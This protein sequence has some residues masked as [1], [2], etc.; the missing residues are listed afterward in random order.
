MVICLNMEIIF[1]LEN[2]DIDVEFKP[3]WVSTENHGDHTKVQWKLQDTPD[4]KHLDD[5]QLEFSSESPIFK[6]N[7]SV[8]NMRLLCGYN[9]GDTDT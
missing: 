2:S 4:T 8:G 3:D 1:E 7:V 9:Q 5:V 6:S